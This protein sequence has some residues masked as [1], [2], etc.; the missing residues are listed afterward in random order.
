MGRTRGKAEEERQKTQAINILGGGDEDEG[1]TNGCLI[2][3]L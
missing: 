1:D 2:C 3:Q